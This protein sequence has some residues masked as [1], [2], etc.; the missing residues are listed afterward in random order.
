MPASQDYVWPDIFL[1]LL[2]ETSSEREDELKLACETIWILL[3][4]EVLRPQLMSHREGKVIGVWQG[5][6]R[7]PLKHH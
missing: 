7:D 3:L 2:T 5:L 1:R 4:S 6:A